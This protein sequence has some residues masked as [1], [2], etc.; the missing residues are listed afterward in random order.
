MAAAVCAGA[1]A[2]AAAVASAAP[3]PSASHAGNTLQGAGYTAGIVRTAYG[4][5]HI[6][7]PDY[8]SLGFGYGYAFASDD[9]CTMADDYVTVEGQ[10]SRYFGPDGTYVQVGLPAS[11]NIDSDFYWKQVVSSGTISRL[12]A[13]TSG[14]SAVT[15]QVR[16]LVEGYVA[17]Y[18][19]Y[20]ASVGGARGLSDPT[21]R[22]QAWVK[23]ITVL[24]EY[25]RL[26]QVDDI[27]GVAGDPG[28]WNAAQ[29]PAGPAGSSTVAKAAKQGSAS[30]AGHVGHVGRVAG[31]EVNALAAAPTAGHANGPGSNALAIGAQGARDHGAGILLGNPHFPWNGAER[32]Y[33]VQLTIPGQLDVEGASLYGTPLVEIGFNSSVAFTHTDTPSF[34]FSLYQLTLVPGHPTEY[35]YDGRP[36]PM[37][38]QTETVLEK[39]AGTGK[40]EPVSRTVYS[41]RYGPVI[42]E[43]QG[44]ALPWT[45]DTAFVIADANASNF[46]FMDDILAAD[47]ATST[48]GILAEQQEY[49][50]MPWVDTIAADAAG[51][52]LYTDIGAFPD[53]SDAVATSCDTPLGTELF[54]L[55]GLPVMD[56]SRPDCVWGTD[57]GA[58]QPGI[59]SA[60]EEP[61]LSR[62]D[63]VENSNESYWLTNAS[64]PMTG[65][66]RI[67]G[68]TD[69]PTSLR[70][71][72]ALTMVQN[73]IAGT[74]G[75][76]PA[77]FTLAGMQNLMYSDIQ[78]GATLVKPQLLRLCRSL[79]GGLAPTSAGGTV[80][81]GDAC[82]VLAAWND[83]E[84]PQSRGAALFRDFWERSFN[85]PEGPWATPYD[86][87]DPVD[88][89]TG[90]NVGDPAVAQAFGDALADFRAAHVPFDVPLGAVQYVVRNGA[91]I[92][93]PGGPGDPDGEFNVYTPSA[94]ILTHPGG[95]P[96][97]GSSYIQ[98][99]TWVKGSGCPVA[100]TMLTYSESTNPDS[101]HYADQTALY[102]HKGWVDAPYCGAAVRAQAVSTST[103]TGS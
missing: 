6:T 72:S 101:P 48:A 61:T 80:A 34:S 78:Y 9:L 97:F 84:E 3:A 58:A 37:T 47:Q 18:D 86:P 66:P 27:S 24:D 68:L 38:A 14:P 41:T 10:R 92:P 42:N 43:L 32:M 91:H 1:A 26:Y 28:Q 88:T 15:P 49:E 7:A 2:S 36:T 65:F 79:P 40:L 59:F 31:V 76:G 98:A 95:D 52:T 12:L 8:G 60:R 16:K 74:D 54:T 13:P 85:I 73:R 53:I 57:P 81:V 51:H 45:Q 35:L 62:S 67:L 46:R 4:I 102:S 87:A 11:K 21:C 25:L 100:R 96:G 70:T 63:Y 90:L 23:P 56:A 71:R 89:P 94:D 20:L 93:I 103:V 64:H 75:L 82:A 99:V 83:R 33:Q 5:P 44:V 77:G 22:G 39:S 50:G 69:S 29:P 17:G 19:H 55:A 30:A